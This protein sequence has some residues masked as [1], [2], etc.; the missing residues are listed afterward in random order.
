MTGY[1][2]PSQG[3]NQGYF[4]TISGVLWPLDRNQVLGNGIIKLVKIISR[5][6]S[7]CIKGEHY[8]ENSFHKVMNAVCG[9]LE[10]TTEEQL[11]SNRALGHELP[12]L[13]AIILY[14]KG[15]GLTDLMPP[16]TLI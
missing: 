16:G 1:S 6:T 2:S 5:E 13:T 10:L 7:L 12:F 3:C 11:H 8:S 15:T 9:L 14:P 4:K